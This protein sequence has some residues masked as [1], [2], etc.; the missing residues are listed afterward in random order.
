MLSAFRALVIFGCR[1]EKRLREEKRQ[2][3]RAVG[4]YVAPRKMSTSVVSGG[5]IIS[6]WL[7]VS[8]SM[9][10]MWKKWYTNKYVLVS[11]GI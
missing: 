7:L 1:G 10:F 11:Y 4:A 3:Q 8:L 5:S 9:K 2:R 6:H